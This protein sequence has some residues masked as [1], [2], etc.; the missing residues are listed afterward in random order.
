M[1]AH[2]SK[3]LEQQRK[4]GSIEA[5]MMQY[6]KTACMTL[7]LVIILAALAL[8]VLFDLRLD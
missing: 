3:L 2:N 6:E 1:N 7:I 4:L 8:G 5:R